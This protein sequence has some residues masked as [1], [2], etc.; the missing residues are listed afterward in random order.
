M[1]GAPAGQWMVAVDC[2]GVNCSGCS[3]ILAIA[4]VLSAGVM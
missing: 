1:A 4:E 3:D 2:G